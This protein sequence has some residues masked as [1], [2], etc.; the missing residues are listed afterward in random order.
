MPDEEKVKEAEKPH[1]L[2]DLVKAAT[3]RKG[4]SEGGSPSGSSFVVYLILIGIAV[5]G[6]SIMGF[7]LVRSRREAAKLAYELR[8]KEEEQKQ[9][10]ED[11]KLAENGQKRNEAHKKV[12]ALQNDIDELKKKLEEQTALANARSK[13]ISDA[14]SWDDLVVVDRRD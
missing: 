1:L 6:F 8:K 9:A 3:E 14:T 4:S 2:V 10:A 11:H 7:L 12:K 13:A 5:L